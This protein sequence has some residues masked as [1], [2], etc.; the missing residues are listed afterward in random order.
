[1]NIIETKIQEYLVSHQIYPF[2]VL[3]VKSPE[4]LK[5]SFH[6]P[7]DIQEFLDLSGYSKICD[8]TGVMIFPDTIQMTGTYL[9][10]FLRDVGCI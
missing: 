6:L 8:N 1:M 7:S 5:I 2:S 9:L 3:Y 4:F 10:N